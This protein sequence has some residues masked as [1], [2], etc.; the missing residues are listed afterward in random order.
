MTAPNRRNGKTIDELD[1]MCTSK[2][3]YSDE[4]SA[5]GSAQHSLNSSWGKSTAFLWVYQCPVC[6]GWHMTSSPNDSAPV[7]RDNLVEDDVNVW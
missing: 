1:R 5:R 2:A 7:S 4:Y 3:R 6:R